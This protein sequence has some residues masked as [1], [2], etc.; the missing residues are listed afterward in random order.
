[1]GS[2]SLEG[3]RAQVSMHHPAA[4]LVA[5]RKGTPT[6]R[7][8]LIP[9]CPP[10]A[11]TGRPPAPAP[12]HLN[13]SRSPESRR[14]LLPTP[15][16]ALAGSQV[17]SHSLWRA[18]DGQGRLW[19]G[20]PDLRAHVDPRGLAWTRLGDLRIRRLAVRAPPAVLLN[21]LQCKGFRSRTAPRPSDVWSHV[22]S[23]KHMR[24]A[25]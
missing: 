4:K 18:V 2:A 1:M 20:T 17:G 11:H 10:H 5:L 13:A 25:R 3:H 14:Q 15:R 12:T 24:S 16:G 6:I 23:Q 9:S 19:M 8:C 21:P 7:G 22:G